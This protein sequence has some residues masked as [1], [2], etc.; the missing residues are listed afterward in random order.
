MKSYSPWV[1]VSVTLAAPS[2]EQV[3]ISSKKLILRVRD[4]MKEKKSLSQSSN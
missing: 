1:I 3:I 2:T 4:K